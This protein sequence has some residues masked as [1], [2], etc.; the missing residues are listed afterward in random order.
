[1]TGAAWKTPETPLRP[2]TMRRVLELIDEAQRARRAAARLTRPKEPQ[3]G[4]YVRVYFMLPG[5]G[6][7]TAMYDTEN[8]GDMTAWSENANLYAS[9]VMWRGDEK[10]A[11]AAAPTKG[12]E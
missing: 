2:A 8:P 10:T 4:R 1:M 9:Q 11:G 3:R 5:L 12:D 6:V 7:H